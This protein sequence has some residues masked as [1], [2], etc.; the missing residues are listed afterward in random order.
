MAA[1]K[2]INERIRE[3]YVSEDGEWL[4]ERGKV[5]E[6]KLLKEAC[7][8]LERLR[9]SNASLSNQ[10]NKAQ[11]D[12]WKKKDKYDEKLTKPL[13]TKLTK[14]SGDLK[15]AEAKLDAIKKAMTYNY[16]TNY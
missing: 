7:V 10:I 8:E 4:Y 9:K 15:N 11:W 16:F 5:R 2:L 6:A 13:Q 12:N 1:K 14:T 3:F